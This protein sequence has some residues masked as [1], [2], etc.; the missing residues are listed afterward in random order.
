MKATELD[1]VLSWSS[2]WVCESV[3]KEGRGIFFT[4]ELEGNRCTGM[5]H[6]WV[7]EK[8]GT[9][10]PGEGG[11]QLRV[12]APHHLCGCHTSVWQPEQTRPLR[13]IRCGW[14]AG[15]PGVCWRKKFSV[16]NQQYLHLSI[17][18][19]T[20]LT[21]VNLLESN[22][23]KENINSFRKNFP[24]GEIKKKIL[25][26]KKKKN[27]MSSTDC[28]RKKRIMQFNKRWWSLVDPGHFTDPK[29][30]ERRRCRRPQAGFSFDF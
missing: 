9:K 24:V 17:C 30:E 28:F 29:P 18:S 22:D 6:T 26:Q 15:R 12:K 27:L 10:P 11:G 14:L 23:K 16:R 21:T 8:E 20:A 25:R 19:P 5:E 7:I 3:G 13:A 1:K 4:G 2:E